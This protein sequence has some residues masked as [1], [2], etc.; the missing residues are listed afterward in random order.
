M[1]LGSTTYN[2]VCNSEFGDFYGYF[3]NSNKKKPNAEVSWYKPTL[4]SKPTKFV[5]QMA[6]LTKTFNQL[7]ML[8]KS[9]MYNPELDGKI[10]FMVNDMSKMLCYS[11]KA[12][13]ETD[14]NGLN[15]R[16]VLVYENSTCKYY[17]HM[18][19]FICEAPSVD[20]GEKCQDHQFQCEDRSC[21]VGKIIII[22]HF[23][24]EESGVMY[25]F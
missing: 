5:V 23:A 24:L 9:V 1:E 13:T 18:K 16:Q 20:S 6:N 4:P 2:T 22:F 25:N 21:I 10:G 19:G 17:F 8:L 12:Q 15:P 7:K 14:E 11:I 3:G